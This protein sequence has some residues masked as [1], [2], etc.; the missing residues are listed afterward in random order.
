M[1]ITPEAI[2]AKL[3]I[4]QIKQSIHRHIQPI[5]EMLPDKRMG[6]VIEVILLGIL[7]GQTPVITGIA[8]QNSKEDGESWATAKRIYRLLENKRLKTSDVYEGLYKIGQQ[9]VEQEHPDYL[10]VAVDPVNF[11]KPYVKAIEGVSVV[12]KATPP[13]LTGQ[14]RLAK[15]Y[16]A[17]TATIVNTKVPV[18]SY[19]NWFSYKTADFISQNKEIEQAFQTTNRLYQ[20]YQVR[21]VGDSGLDDQKMFAQVGKLGQEFVFRASHLE[22]IVEVYNTRLDRWETEALQDLAETVLYQA[23]F[24]VLFKHA[25][26]SRLDTIQFG[27]FTIR[28]PDNPKQ[29]LWVLV[30]DDQDLERQ[31]ALITNIPLENTQ[32][33][34]QVYNDWRLRP[35]IEHG[36][37]FD[38]EQGLDV[39]DMRVQTV[40]RMRRLFAFVL[41]SAQMV[42]VIGEQWP[43]KAV[44]WLR[45]LGGKLGLSCDRDGPYWLLHGISAVIVSASTLSFAFLHPFPFGENTYG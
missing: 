15:G 24:K 40:E 37:R 12:H 33:V 19:A 22:R 6:S 16:P 5:K 42:F 25:G 21:F 17:I 1:N 14:A 8:R 32:I 35:R 13:D 31:L 20:G 7:G 4:E 29:I 45:H 26:H 28:L 18:T 30:A 3:P 41:L 39:E 23:T 34:Q 38:Q 36:Y 9:V 11:E 44:L 2:L 43:P 10:V 27:W